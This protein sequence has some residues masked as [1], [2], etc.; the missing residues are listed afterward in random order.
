MNQNPSSDFAATWN[1]LAQK[2]AEQHW[3]AGT[4]YVVATPIGNLGDL[5]LRAWQALARCDV[6]AAEDTRS[7][8]ALLD[9]WGIS[10]PLLAAHRHNEAGAAQTLLKRLEQGERVGLISDAGAPAVSDP[11]ARIVRSARQAGYPVVAIPGASAVITALMA[12]G[13]TSDENPAFIFAGFAPAK[14]G[15]RQK[16]LKYW[17]A[18]SAPV[19]VFESPHR[20]AAAF[21]DMLEVCGPDRKLT[22]ARELTK[23]FEEV[24]TMTLGQAAQW[25]AEDTHRGQGEFVLIVH[26]ALVQASDGNELDAA[27]LGLLDALLEVASV[28]DAARVAA[29]ATGVARDVLYAEALKRAG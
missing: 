12:S 9:A 17:T 11:G 2:V 20:L 10:T 3:P 1:R 7:S 4:L 8:R 27:T 15:A 28:R 29:K 14:S 5:S 13:V 25:L 21:K 24:A 6:I 22:V 26:E 16:W 18:L 23:R 19:V